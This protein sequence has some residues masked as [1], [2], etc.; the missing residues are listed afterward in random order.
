MNVLVQRAIYGITALVIS[1][2][3]GFEFSHSG[4]IPGAWD[5]SIRLAVAGVFLFVCAVIPDLADWIIKRI[6]GTAATIWHMAVSWLWKAQP[7][8]ED[9]R[10]PNLD[11]MRLLLALSVFFHHCWTVSIGGP[12]PFASYAAV[13]TFLCIS[14]FTVL[15]SFDR[16]AT[17]KQFAVKRILRVAPAFLMSIIVLWFIDGGGEV[18]SS[19]I[20]WLTLGLTHGHAA[21]GTYWSL[22]CEEICY[23]VLAVAYIL[24]AYR[25]PV[26][27]WAGLIIAFYVMRSIPYPPDGFALRTCTLPTAFFA[28]NLMYIYRARLL[29]VWPWIPALGAIAVCASL[30]HIAVTP[31]EIIPHALLVAFG[32]VWFCLAGPTLKVRLTGDYSYGLYIYHQPI[33]LAIASHIHIHSFALVSVVALSTSLAVS[34]LSWEMVEK[35]FL[36][37]KPC[38]KPRTGIV[39][40]ATACPVQCR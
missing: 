3:S 22:S 17:W 4:D 39:I 21:A 35:R 24:G 6:S 25:R 10:Y 29:R 16:S 11:V 13:P 32:L 34:W 14:G 5:M 33:L 1:A 8:T 30:T 18:K 40:K 27:A 28:G 19:L 38:S 23:A 26:F 20:C 31:E 12:H 9:Q 15:A 2:I 7:R 36:K 37:L